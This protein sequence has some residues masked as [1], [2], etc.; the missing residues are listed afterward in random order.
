MFWQGKE[1]EQVNEGNTG[2][3]GDQQVIVP[4]VIVSRKILSLGSGI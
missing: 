2:L 4:E 1:N 3:V